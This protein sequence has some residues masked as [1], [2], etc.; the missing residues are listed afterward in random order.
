MKR[1]FRIF[2]ILL[3]ILLLP[4]LFIFSKKAQAHRPVYYKQDLFNSISYLETP[5][6]FTIIDVESHSSEFTKLEYPENRNLTKLLKKSD[7]LLWLKIEFEIPK[8]LKNKDI[9]LFIGRL[10]SSSMLYINSKFIR[11]YGST[12]PAEMTSGYV[13]QYY[14]FAKN[15]VNST[16][17]NTVYIQVWPGPMGAISKN[18]YISEQAEIFRRAE[19]LS[20]FNSKFILTF[21]GLSVFIAFLYFVLYFVLRKHKE[22]RMYLFYALTNFYTAHFLLYF[23][24]T[25]ISWIKPP[26]ISYLSILKFSLCYGG[27]TTAY[28]ASSFISS[29]LGYDASKKEMI[30]RLVLLAI[31]TL[32]SFTLPNDAM[33]IKYMPYLIILVLAQFG[34]C[35]PR[36]IRDLINKEKRKNV[37]HILQAFSPLYVTLTIDI[38]IHILEID[39]TPIF[40]LYGWQV[41][42]YIFLWQLLKQ[43]GNMYI[44]NTTLKSQ[45]EGFNSNLENVVAIRTKELSD[46]N[47][48]LS[49]GLETVAHVQKNFLPP[50]NNVFR[51]WDIS[52]YYQPL[53]NNVSGDLYDYYTTNSSLDG[54][55]IFDVSGHGIPAGLMTILAKGIIS[56]HFLNGLAQDESISDILLEIND[57]YI[58]EKVNV[59][60]YITGLLFHFSDFN[61]NDICSVEL[62]NAG[63]PYPILYNAEKDEF[64]EIRPEN[65]ERQYGIIGVE[66]LDVSFPPVSFRMGK[67]DIIVCFTD[68]IIEALNNKREEF[69]KERLMQIIDENKKA[70]ASIIL[71]KIIYSLKDFIQDQNPTDDITVI[72]LKRTDSNEYIEEI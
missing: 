40:T 70:P 9:G 15:D 25:E 51:G 6:R 58:K 45:L 59:E 48:V 24:L 28:F 39:D 21:A 3:A 49:R 41:T 8:E 47:Y 2:I 33:F 23:F 38:I 35:V 44:H 61:K 4:G 1:F 54:I 71:E 36:I 63:H 42:I 62:A 10:R 55:G 68:G 72:V 43:F 12:P 52:I 31:P 29:Y 18:V 7:N 34:F 14:M 22:I 53:D 50:E 60:N 32:I 5:L 46:A 13:A 37:F 20:Y 11:K 66:G 69:S 16:G 27:F 64:S 67:D 65:P 57:T 17:I 26:F 56:Q 19:R 30:V